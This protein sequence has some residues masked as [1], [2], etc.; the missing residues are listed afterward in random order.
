MLI[1]SQVQEL[2][3][4]FQDDYGYEVHES[5]I[6]SQDGPRKQLN[7]DLSDFVYKHDKPETLLIVYY[8]GHGSAM[9]AKGSTA[10]SNSFTLSE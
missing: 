8:A 2:G 1:P 9:P 3:Q 6:N 4:V 10:A 5:V 7:R